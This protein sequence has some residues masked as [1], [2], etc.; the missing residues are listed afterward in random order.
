MRCYTPGRPRADRSAA[1]L[2]ERGVS[3]ERVV[4][5]PDVGR[6]L[7]IPPDTAH[8]T[9]D[10]ATCQMSSQYSRMARSDENLP[11]RAVLRIDI[12]VHRS[13]SCHAAPT[14]SWQAT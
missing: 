6:R 10:A 5:Q 7:R 14:C 9:G 12:R 13:T 4:Q 1:E 3:R 2:K 8:S 11:L